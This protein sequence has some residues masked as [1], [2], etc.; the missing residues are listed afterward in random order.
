[1]RDQ[2][3]TIWF[4]FTAFGCEG[5]VP[6]EPLESQIIL[7]GAENIVAEYETEQVIDIMLRKEAE[8]RAAAEQGYI[9]DEWISTALLAR[10]L[11]GVMGYKIPDVRY[12]M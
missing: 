11:R 10:A 7:T 1:M 8:L 4:D 5:W 12:V 6:V 3:Q 9:T 2:V